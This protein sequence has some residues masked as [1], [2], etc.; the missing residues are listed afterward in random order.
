MAILS[1]DD[2]LALVERARE[3]AP[4]ERRRALEALLA[5]FRGAALAA[6]YR[7]LVACGVRGPAAL[8]GAADEAL[9]EATLKLLA[10]GLAAFRGQSSP[11]TYFVRIAL[12]A[13][14]DAVRRGSRSEPLD[15]RGP[16]PE[17]W[18]AATPS[19]EEQLAAFELRRALERCLDELRP[20]YR[21]SVELYYLEELG[22]CATCAR[23]AGTTADAFMQQLSRARAR[24]ADCL[25]RRLAVVP[26]AQSKGELSAAGGEPVQASEDGSD[27]ER[28]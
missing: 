18:A 28:P 19:A 15:E 14:L 20:R 12:N 10:G 5:D 17:R 2:Q 23:A 24:L 11:R 22:D 27:G 1:A 25:R 3:G 9:Q 13:A 21:R 16:R 6:I 26:E 4:E 7:T 8:R